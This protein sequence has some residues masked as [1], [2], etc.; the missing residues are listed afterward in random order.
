MKVL[1]QIDFCA[2]GPRPWAGL[3]L[4]GVAAAL[5]AVAATTYWQ[6]QS[7]TQQ[8]LARMNERTAR[9]L[10][11]LSRKLNEA[12]RQQLAR[13]SRI[14]TDLNAPWADL[15]ATFEQHSQ[16]DIGLLKLEPDAHAALVRVTG[17]ARNVSAMFDYVKALEADPRLHSVALTQHLLER[18]SPGQPLRFTL[19]A[20]WRPGVVARK[21]VF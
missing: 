4:C 13:A 2:R 9:Q 20:G 18:E 16:A 5:L 19:Q 7:E 3:T 6:Q 11:A 12:D 15:L 14:A 1:P 17:H 10:P 8:A 21:G